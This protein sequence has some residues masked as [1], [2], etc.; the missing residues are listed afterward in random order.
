MVR[1][2]D[3]NVPLYENAKTGFIFKI[4]P[5]LSSAVMDIT[6]LIIGVCVCVCMYIYIYICD[7]YHDSIFFV[8]HI[9]CLSNTNSDS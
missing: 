3:K 2:P 6:R 4:F 5:A 7:K 8:P 1:I 9:P